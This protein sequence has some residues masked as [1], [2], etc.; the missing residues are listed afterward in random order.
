M[1]IYECPDC[2]TRS[3]CDEPVAHTELDSKETTMPIT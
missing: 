2:E 1:T 3:H